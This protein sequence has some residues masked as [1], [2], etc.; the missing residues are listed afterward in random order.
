[1]K[2]FLLH[3][4]QDFDLGRNLPPN[5][6]ALTQ[7][8]ELNTLFNAMALG[9]TF[10]FDV[11]RNVVFSS[12]HD[13]VAI[14]YR[15]QVLA[16]CLAQS[17]VVRQIYDLA[18]GAIQAERKVWGIYRTSSPDSILYRSVQV[19]VIFVDFLKRLRKLCGEAAGGFHS[20]GFVRFFAM[21][22]SELDD[23]YF[24][25][26]AAHL[27]TLQFRHGVQISAEL[28]TGNKGIHYVLRSPRAQRWWERY[29][30][31]SH[32]SFSFQLAERDESG[33][34]ALAD[35]RGKGIN[36]V[37][38]ALAQSTDHILS[39]FRMMRAEFAFY[40][41]CLNLHAQL[42]KK[43]EPMCFPIPLTPDEHTFSAQGLYDVCLSLHL[44]TRAVGN[45]VNA[46]NK[47]LVII[48]GAN[49]G[50]K[51]TFLR[52][53]GLAH[54]MMQSGMLVPAASLKATVCNG[55]FTHYRR[56]EDASMTSGKLDEELSRMSGIADA[57]TPNSLLLCNE[58]FAATNEREGSEIARQITRALIEAG[59]K[60]FFVTHLFDFAHGYYRQKM[61][62]VLLLRAERQPDGQRT[63][64]LVEGEPLPTSYG[65]DAY[66][67]IFHPVSRPP[68]DV[69]TQQA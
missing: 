5:E 48:T 35:L 64:R 17:A 45:D 61:D 43:G 31:T 59:I 13:P 34:R 39:F 6:G 26:I 15:Q 65:E 2:V 38:N 46:D 55:I 67:R 23:D 40:V 10:L 19:L 20:E 18:V 28:G 50:G 60:V 4:D 8:L 44:K 12:L 58:S 25:T 52:S 36:L 33:F 68:L 41:G 54:L 11:A 27:R 42:L 47:G 1:M 16:D 24:R 37:A 7:D 66:Q 22:E 3:R 9:D 62:T 56:E 49:Q 14:R 21:L 69:S 32:S 30:P 57:I 53:I 29:V 51:S 63:F